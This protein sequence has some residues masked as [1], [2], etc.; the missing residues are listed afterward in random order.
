MSAARRAAEC[1]GA[2]LVW[3]VLC[4]TA[5]G[6]SAPLYI[7]GS[8]AAILGGVGGG[9]QHRT[10]GAALLRGLTGG[11]LFGGAILLGFGLFGGPEPTVPLPEPTV[12]L[13]LF[14][15]VP[16]LALHYLGWRLRA[17]AEAGRS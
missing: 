17:R 4:G 10:R 3:G 2:P 12:L 5:L 6:L 8:V 15:T 7:A 14:T 1:P 16:S 13:L 9:A 11:L